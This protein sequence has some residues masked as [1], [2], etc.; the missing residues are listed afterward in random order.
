MSRAL[1]VDGEKDLAGIENV[2]R[3]EGLLDRTH[4]CHGRLPR[5]VDKG[6]ALAKTDAVLARACAAE[7][8]HLAGELLGRAMGGIARHDVGRIEKQQGVEV[9]V[10]NVAEHRPHE[11][12]P[13]EDRLGTGDSLG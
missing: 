12:L 7:G 3:V 4:D 11:G 9:A 8:N 6:L 5:L 13:G 1:R 2:A 10:G